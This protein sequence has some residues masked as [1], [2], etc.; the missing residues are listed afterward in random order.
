MGLGRRWRLG[1]ATLAALLA[2]V[3]LGLGTILQAASGG[4]T[5]GFVQA[6]GGHASSTTSLT[7]TPTSN[8]LAGNRLVVE[9][10]V[11]SNAGATAASVTDSAGNSYVELLHFTAPDK[12]EMSVWTAPIVAGAG[13][14]PTIA[15]KPT[16][17]ADVG[18]V[19]LEY[20]GISPVAD[21]SVVDRSAMASGKTGSAAAVV[22]S[23]ATAATTAPNELALGFY[24]DSGFGDTLTGGAGY[25]TR[26]NIS[27]DGDVEL[28]AEDAVV[29]EGATPNA[30]VGTGKATWWLAS[31]VV[32]KTVGEPPPPTVPGPPTQVKAT[33]GNSSA[34]VSWTAP[35]NGNSA[36]TSYTVTPYRESTALAPTTVTG[37]PPLT[38]ATV[39]GLTNGITYTFKVTA[40]NG[41]GTGPASEASNAVVPT[42]SNE[43]EWSSLMTWPFEAIHVF[44]LANGNV[45]AMDGWA[46][47]QPTYVWNPST[48]TFT[49]STAPAA[50]FCSGLAQLAN[51]EVMT[52]GGYG[53]PT[54][55]QLGLTATAI[56]N[57]QTGTWRSAASMHNPR[58]YPSVT[59]LANGEYVAISGN[60]RSA[61][62]WADTPEIYNVAANTWTPLSNVSTS[63]IHEEEYPFSFLDPNGE[64]FAIGPSEDVSYLL[65]VA[66]ESWTSVGPSGIKNGSSV[67]YRP[68]KILYSGGAP[69]ISQPT[70][71]TS[72]AATI[73]VTEASPK[74]K[75]T[76]PMHSPRIYHTLTT[77]ADGTVLA[78]GGEGSSDQSIVTT[79]VL[80]TEIWNPTTETWTTTA[81]IAAARNY[82][83]TAI[84]LPDGRV[85]SAGGG[86]STGLSGPGQ[87]NAQIYSPPYLS[88]GP[89]PTITAAP[90]ASTY[91]QSITV[92]T[93][94]AS[95]IHAV[96]L[97]SIGA[98]T[99]QSN[100]SQ[101]FIPL[102][103]TAGQ[104]SLTVQT[105]AS[106][107]LAPYGNYMLFILNEK[108][109]PS[110]SAPLN[111]S[112]APEAPGAPTNVLATA[113]GTTA[114][115]TWG[116]PSQGTSAITS[117][118]VTPYIGETAQEPTVVNGTPPAASATITGLTSGVT[119]TFKVSATNGVGTGPPSAPSSPITISTPTAPGAPTAVSATPGNASASINW[120]APSAN[121][122]PITSY[123]ITPYVGTTAGTPT[124]VVGSPPVTGTTV[125]GL[126]NGTTYTF[127]VTATNGIGT[128]PAS[129]ASNAVTPTATAAAAF[130]Q[131]ATAHGHGANMSVIPASN[132]TAGNRLI[133]EV[134]VWNSAHATTSKVEDTAGDTFTEL[135][136]FAAS[137][138]TEMSVWSAPITNGGGTRPTI[139][140]TPG[141]AADVGVAALEYSG[142]SNAAGS[143]VVDQSAQAS[144][145][146]TTAG[147]V[148]TPATAPTTAP[149][150]LVMGFYADS[151]FGDK[152]MAKMG[153]NERVNVSPDEDMEFV[154]EDSLTGATGST[155]ASGAQTGPATVWLMATIAFKSASMTQALSAPLGAPANL[156]A[157]PGN[158]SATLTWSSPRNGGSQI[159]RYRITPYARHR[160]LPPVYASG[161]S[162]VVQGLQNGVRYRFRVEAVNALGNGPESKLSNETVPEGWLLSLG[163]CGPLLSPYI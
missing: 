71:S 139:T 140:A 123:T 105:P 8:V 85:L 28:L 145:K 132:L 95:S 84:L 129:A 44:Q 46:N 92:A 161:N 128:G 97:I 104:G 137:D 144:G 80:P 94:D 33:A 25:T 110:V 151:G 163:W 5:P 22:S 111:L 160:R 121:G 57:P 152:L 76:A 69:S 73:D 101:H 53:L 74:W 83:S 158:G 116:V 142:L 32:L 135:L 82:H 15:V 89:R 14:R 63:Q 106:A 62:A 37:T 12:T 147:A 100:M 154:V 134:G 49:S 24:L 47:P 39:G 50:I 109:V 11:W 117:Y 17:K 130:V 29:S 61:T 126:T 43:G 38:S 26:A 35:S 120:T 78:I 2:L 23:G 45:L 54:T 31:T 1:W 48:N 68:G 159:T 21:A 146:T 131:K 148:A 114:T 56:F 143:A 153:F 115:V 30:T 88:N 59:E 27:P 141:S 70:S 122:S 36:I 60:S 6:V 103:F 10:G 79:G 42:E 81:P 136:H 156:L 41:V 64:V 77:L 133:V 52:V 93:P 4:T 119:Y 75:P 34:A 7:L 66:K 55:G 87:F 149:N 91:G 113:S 20:S 108:G 124:T 162:A 72:T 125:T 67:M 19:A 157:T 9:V 102:S 127:T 155:P 58:W 150:E 86:H 107:A 98:D 90:A 138:G 51:G 65:N 18:G 16:A 112:A 96:N 40:T 99:H 13:S 118:T 3:C